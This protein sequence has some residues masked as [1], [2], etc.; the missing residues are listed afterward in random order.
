MAGTKPSFFDEF[1]FTKQF[2]G[3]ALDAVSAVTEFS[4][5]RS[6]AQYETA[7]KQLA[8]WTQYAETSK[9][10]YRDYEMQLQSWYRSADY[11]ERMRTYQAQLQEQA[12]EFKGQVATTAT[13][14]FEKQLA[15]LDGQYYE[16][17][18][19]DD[20]E[21]H[22][23]MVDNFAKASRKAASGQVGRTVQAINNQFNQQHLSNISNRQITRQF[24]LADK[25][26]QA[27]ALNVAR[28]N[29]TNQARFYTPQQYADP[30]KPLAPLPITAVEP[31]AK[32]GP[33]GGALALKL[34]GA[35]ADRTFDYIDSLPKPTDTP[36]KPAQT[37][38]A[39]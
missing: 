10:N 28:E 23:L 38:T 4:I 16:E 5:A 33:S 19:K 1:E 37:E 20:I 35:A 7:E 17:E 25:I 29:Q 27:E 2:G 34:I 30:V 3:F 31:L 9:K 32:Q 11:T 15:D 24:R 21:I 18:A 6:N 8:Y 36:Q 13:K 26:R 39:K 22:R 12:A 14:N